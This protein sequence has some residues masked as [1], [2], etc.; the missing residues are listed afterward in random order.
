MFSRN[1]K[2]FLRIYSKKIIVRNHTPQRYVHDH[3]IHFL[4]FL[5]SFWFSS[6]D[7]PLT[8]ILIVFMLRTSSRPSPLCRDRVRRAPMA[9][10]IDI[11]SLYLCPSYCLR[12]L[13]KPI[14]KPN[15]DE[16]WKGLVPFFFFH[17]GSLPKKN[18][19]AVPMKIVLGFFHARVSRSCQNFAGESFLKKISYAS[20]SSVIT[21]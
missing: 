21:L 17:V 2:G 18:V 20:T 15:V 12:Y 7:S 5:I 11:G 6:F 9:E 4:T 3:P 8:A 10:L 14:A 16:V 19:W 13:S 1:F